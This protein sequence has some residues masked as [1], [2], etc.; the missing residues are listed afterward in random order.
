[1]IIR[2]YVAKHLVQLCEDNKRI[3]S[4]QLLLPAN[5]FT[6][7]SEAWHTTSWLD[8]CFSTA[9]AHASISSMAI[10]YDAS[11]YDH[12]PFTLTV[13]CECLPESSQEAHTAS[14]PKL[15]WSKLSSE[16]FLK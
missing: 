7:V 9:D 10:Q 14:T 6:Y 11:M 4:S 15:D 12:V 2:D 13:E 3:L 8:H 1:M 16:D 5:S